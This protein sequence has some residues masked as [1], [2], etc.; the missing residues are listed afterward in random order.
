MRKM[1]FILPSVLVISVGAE[2]I[3]GANEEFTLIR[4]AYNKRVDEEVQARKAGKKK[5]PKS[6][7]E[8]AILN[9][10]LAAMRY[11]NTEL[12]HAVCANILA[13][14]AAD[15]EWG[16]IIEERRKEYGNE[17]AEGESGEELK[18][19]ANRFRETSRKRW[20]VELASAV[21][22]CVMVGENNAIYFPLWAEEQ[23]VDTPVLN[24]KY[25]IEDEET[26]EEVTFCGIGVRSKVD[27]SKYKVYDRS[28]GGLS[29]FL[30]D[31]SELKM[32][33]EILNA[34]WSCEVFSTPEGV[35]QGMKVTISTD[36]ISS[37]K[38]YIEDI[39]RYLVTAF[40]HDAKTFVVKRNKEAASSS[41]IHSFFLIRKY[42][43]YEIF[44]RQ[45]HFLFANE[46]AHSVSFGILFKNEISKESR[47]V[48]NM[49]LERRKERPN[50]SSGDSRKAELTS[51][52]RG[53]GE[54]MQKV[55]AW[56]CS[57][58]S[59]R[60]LSQYKN[61]AQQ[62]YREKLQMIVDL[63]AE[64]AVAY[65]DEG[66][67]RHIKTCVNAIN[68]VYSKCT[69]DWSRLERCWSG[70]GDGNPTAVVFDNK[71][72]VVLSALGAILESKGSRADFKD[73]RDD[74]WLNCVCHARSWKELEARIA[75]EKE[76]ER[77]AKEARAEWRE[78]RKVRAEE[79]R[80]A[81]LRGIENAI[82]D[83]PR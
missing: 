29:C 61:E 13:E 60:D 53:S 56:K 44:V 18:K 71:F 23:A 64:M 50:G 40:Q 76:Q 59:S 17:F 1:I 27:F 52:E 35:C 24:Q 81:V 43:R 26:E 74:L 58:I 73:R 31:R 63:V 25:N 66:S 36:S 62:E 32:P 38:K 22:K 33:D 70:A 82:W 57:H 3:K 83:L 12:S 54:T 9:A 41:A 39:A 11:P 68:F 49:M 42:A 77:K 51:V 46:P 34:R 75:A 28:R 7:D 47:E 80:N 10:M 6:Y 78:E 79:E 72:N 30:V 5:G 4:N 19:I 37:Y 45:A 16:A 67:A 69:R 8:K 48:L 55:K 20:G 2:T 15:R 21:A 65:Q 14:E